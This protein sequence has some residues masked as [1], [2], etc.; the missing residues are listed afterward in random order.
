[1]L[2]GR[3]SL[4]L[5]LGLFSCK[6]LVENYDHRLAKK[7]QKYGFEDHFLEKNGH[8]IFYYDNHNEGAPLLYF[9][10]GFGGDGKLN[11]QNQVKHF[12]DDYRIIIP[13]LLWFGKSDSKSKPTLNAQIDALNLLM[14]ATRGEQEAHLCGISYGG[15][16]VLGFALKHPNTLKSLN[17]VDS[18]GNTVSDEEIEAF[19]NQVGVEN[20][21]EAFIL[22]DADDVQRLL[23]FSFYR[24]PHLPKFVLKQAQNVY[25]SQHHKEQHQLLDNLPKNRTQLKEVEKLDVPTAVYWGEEDIIFSLQNGKDLS[26]RLNAEFYSFSKAGH[27]LPEDA[28]KEFNKTLKKFLSQH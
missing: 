18:P 22:E 26:K 2:F 25:F 28:E 13:D 27:A 23:D 14:L 19:C 7:F 3:L 12:A 1:M 24:P 10:H 20:V 17:I 16:V 15:F 6:S 11:W 4:I 21:N 9:V 5:T 8:K